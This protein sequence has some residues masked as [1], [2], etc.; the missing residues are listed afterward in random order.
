MAAVSY[1]DVTLS[2]RSLYAD[3]AWSMLCLPFDVVGDSQS[4]AFAGTPLEEFTVKELD[5]TSAYNG[6]KTG[7]DNDTL[8]LNFKD[9]TSK[10]KRR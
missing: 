2:G 9:A 1:F 8:Y 3:G 5:V 10:E 4:P 7:F 6:H